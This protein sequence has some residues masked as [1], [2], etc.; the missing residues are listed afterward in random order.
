[1]LL[2]LHVNYGRQKSF[3]LEQI[4]IHTDLTMYS[5]LSTFHTH[6]S[7]PFAKTVTEMALFCTRRRIRKTHVYNLSIVSLE[8]C[9]V[10]LV[11]FNYINFQFYGVFLRISVYASN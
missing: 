9:V 7:S 11:V 1:M 2:G 5:P 3:D 8:V 6:L 4:H 10:F